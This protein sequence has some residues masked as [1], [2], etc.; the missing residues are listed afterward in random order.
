MEPQLC[1][2]LLNELPLYEGMWVPSMPGL[3]VIGQDTSLW[4]YIEMQARWAARVWSGSAPPLPSPERMREL[5]KDQLSSKIPNV[6]LMKF[7]R[8]A[9]LAGVQPSKTE[10]APQMFSTFEPRLMHGIA[11]PTAKFV[12]QKPEFH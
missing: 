8:M 4:Y 7:C 3:A 1:A 6:P 5:T 10:L 2:E 12:C 9:S 11:K